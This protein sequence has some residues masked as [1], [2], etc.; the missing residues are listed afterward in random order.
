MATIRA[1][2]GECGDVDLTT[3]DVRVRVCTDDNSGTYLFRCPRCTMTVVKPA[4]QRTVDL[5]VSS[6]VSCQRWRMP[7]ELLEMRPSGPPIG[8]DDL[9][10]FHEMLDDDALLG[11]LVASLRDT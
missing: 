6:G 7:A 9:L 5:L 2:C 8:H 4:E 11:N 10:E 3:S 1:S